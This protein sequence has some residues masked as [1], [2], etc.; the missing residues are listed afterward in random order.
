M[1]LG[2][3]LR[4]EEHVAAVLETGVRRAILGTRALQ[5]PELVERL[6]GRFGDRLAVGI[7]ARDSRVQVSG[8]VDTTDVDAFDFARQICDLGVQTIIFTDTSRDGM[9][10]GVAADSM[11]KMCDTVSCDV[12]ASGG[13]TTLEDI[14]TLKALSRSNL[15]GAIVGKALYDER[16]TMADLNEV[17]RS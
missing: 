13:V 12:V 1:E 8:W 4:S 5:S 17:A 6:V 10:S 9:M 3:G 15:Q 16:V 14:T 2:G 7:D 11:A